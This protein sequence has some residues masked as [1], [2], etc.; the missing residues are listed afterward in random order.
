MVPKRKAVLIPRQIEQ[1]IQFLRDL[2]YSESALKYSES[3]LTALDLYMQNHNISEYTSEIG[4]KYLEIF[5]NKS[6]ATFQSYRATII[7]FNDFLFENQKYQVKHSYNWKENQKETLSSVFQKILEKYLKS[8]KDTG[9][10]ARTLAIKKACITEF[11]WSTNCTEI[12]SVTASVVAIACTKLNKTYQIQQVLHFLKYCCIESIFQ[13][14]FSTII[15]RCRRPQPLPSIYSVE[16]IQKVEQIIDKSTKVGKRD[17]AM[18]LLASRLG[19]R[20]CDIHNL[21]FDNLDFE[22][23]RLSFIQKKT[24]IELS[25]PM[26]GDV[27]TAI[28]DY[29][30]N[31]RPVS[32]CKKI[33]LNPNTMHSFLK[34]GALGKRVYYY[35]QNAGIPVSGRRRG[36]HIFRSSLATSMIND[37]VPYEAVRKVLG[38]TYFNSVQH[39]AKLDIERLRICALPPVESSGRFEDFLMGGINH[40]RI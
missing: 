18:I 10:S 26:P 33:F 39:Y 9:C 25:L 15:P 37:K 35:L 14:D 11:L 36:S 30:K 27:E 13:Y 19:I 23:H 29:V 31:A 24:G 34:T 5:Q 3:R 16:E 7:R 40:E 22:R 6:L 8:C 32:N 12:K 21:S 17:Y 2:N 4:L 38:H 1:F 28:V 20:A